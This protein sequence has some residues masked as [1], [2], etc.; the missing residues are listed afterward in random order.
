MGK[1]G[2]SKLDELPFGVSA[3]EEEVLEALTLLNSNEIPQYEKAATYSFHKC[4]R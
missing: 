2:N 4:P 1:E 3:S